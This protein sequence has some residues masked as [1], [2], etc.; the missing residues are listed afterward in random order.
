[1]KIGKGV[2]LCKLICNIK[3]DTITNNGVGF[4]DVC[5]VCIVDTDNLNHCKLLP[6]RWVFYHVNY[7][8]R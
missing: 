4:Y 7:Q 1:M 3:S 5:A 2:G 6:H 8:V